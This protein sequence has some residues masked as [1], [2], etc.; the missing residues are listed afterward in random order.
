MYSALKQKKAANKTH[1]PYQL[2]P[3]TTVKSAGCRGE[4][5]PGCDCSP[6]PEVGTEGE[7]KERE[8]QAES[9][10]CLVLLQ[11]VISFSKI[12]FIFHY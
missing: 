10:L 2:W 8:M 5:W 4:G 6:L 9:E 1:T 12:F 11:G 3:G 7:G